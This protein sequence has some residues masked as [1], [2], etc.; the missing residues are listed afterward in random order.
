M[1]RYVY[2]CKCMCVGVYMHVRAEI[3]IVFLSQLFTIVL[4]ET[5]SSFLFDAAFLRLPSSQASS[6][7]LVSILSC[8]DMGITDSAFTWAWGFELRFHVYITSA[9]YP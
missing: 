3:E 8:R 9:L 1:C 2:T 5:G 6:S 7:A 4:F